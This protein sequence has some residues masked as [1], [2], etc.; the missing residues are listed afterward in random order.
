MALRVL[1]VISMLATVAPAAVKRDDYSPS[2]SV[3]SSSTSNVGGGSS[4]V[5]SPSASGSSAFNAP[6]TSSQFTASQSQPYTSQDHS[7]SSPH[8]SSNSGNLYYYYYP[9]Q[10]KPKD[11]GFQAAASNQYTSAVSSPANSDSSSAH[12]GDQSSSSSGSSPSDLS[13]SAQDL[14]YSAQALNPGL[15][16]YTG[17]AQA[18]ANYDQTLS[19]LASQLSQQYGYA[20]SGNQGYGQQAQPTAYNNNGQQAQAT[21]YSA[22]SYTYD[23][24]SHSGSQ[25]QAGQFSASNPVPNYGVGPQQAA[26]IPAQAAPIQFNPAAQAAA[27]YAQYAQAGQIPFGNYP[28]ASIPQSS[29]EPAASGYRRYGIGSF[30]MPMLALAGLSLLIPTVTSLTASGRKK[31]STDAP[32]DIAKESAL[33]QYFDRLERYYSMYKTAVER[34]ECMNRIICELGG[35]VSGSKNKNPIISDTSFRMIEKLIPTWMGNSVG[36]FK[37]SA[38]SGDQSKCKKYTCYPPQ[39]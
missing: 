16:D 12:I 32:V 30:L 38:L 15:S 13:Y 26:F 7:G 17:S 31:R 27:A 25:E 5:Y 3:S 36:I 22:P 18:S 9:V 8:P 28:A 14:T 37:Q 4:P 11:G 29:F 20:P 2:S 24:S 23:T 21:Q 39:K 6:S 34:E 1:L 33:V 35:V 19:S 10:D